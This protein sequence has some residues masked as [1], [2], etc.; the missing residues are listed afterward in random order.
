MYNRILIPLDGSE[1]AEVALPYARG[2]AEKFKGELVVLTVCPQTDAV[3]A[4]FGDDAEERRAGAEQYL[5]QVAANLQAEDIEV[6]PEVKLGRSAPTI[7]DTSEAVAADLMV[8]AT[9]GRSGIAR[10]VLGSTADKVLHAAQ[11][12]VMLIR[13]KDEQP[14]VRTANIF[15]RILVPLDGSAE[16]ESVL[17]HVEALA[18]EFE[19]EIILF[20]SVPQTAYVV[21]VGTEGAYA[22]TESPAE[23]IKA[24]MKDSTDYLEDIKRRFSAKGIPVTTGV[25]SGEP[26]EQIITLAQTNDAGLVAMCTH[27]R[28]GISRWAYGSVATKVLNGGNTPLLLV[29]VPEA[30]PA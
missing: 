2:L 5:K 8:I 10:W 11:K 27:G 26:A 12:P 23:L 14:D 6:T 19:S 30:K 13:T 24:Q 25:E 17:P 4:A 22:M 1:L 7:V 28:S 29:R 3:Y 16:A 18:Q 21:P 9:H 15:R 20:R